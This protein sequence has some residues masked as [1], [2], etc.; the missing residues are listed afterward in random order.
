[1]GANAV[2]RHQPT[3]SDPERMVGVEPGN[4]NQFSYP[5]YQDL[6]RS[7]IFARCAAASGPTS[8]N[9]SFA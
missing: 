1:M 8:L 7:L 3:M 4:A 2:Y 9:M 5:N 6:L